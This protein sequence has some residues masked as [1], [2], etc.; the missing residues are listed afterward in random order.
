MH[1]IKRQ[2]FRLFDKPEKDNSHDSQIKEVTAKEVAQG[3]I[4]SAYFHGADSHGQFR[5]RG[6][7]GQKHKADKSA[8]ELYK[9][10]N[11]F[12]IDTNPVSGK[13]HDCRTN[14]KF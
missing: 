9:L 14:Y 12:P 1:G 7:H 8:A 13:Y 3:Q 5:Q 6:N 2:K 10:A 11:L 4:Q